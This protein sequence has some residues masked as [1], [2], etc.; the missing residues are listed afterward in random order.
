MIF[1]YHNT[2]IHYQKQGRGSAIVLLHG[3]LES[4]TMWNEVAPRMSKKNTV[5]TIDFPGFGQSDPL[6]ETFSMELLASITSEILNL[7]KIQSALLIGHS[8]GGYVGLAFAALF[9]EKIK[10]LILLNSSPRKDSEERKGNRN[11]ALAIIDKNKDAFVNMAI[12]NLFTNEERLHH[13][14][15]I[16]ALK[17]E[18][19][20]I[21]GAAIKA[22]IIG[23]RDRTDTT[24]ILKSFDG[25]KYI[26]SGRLDPIIPHNDIVAISK[27][28]QTS[29]HTIESGHMSW[30]TNWN[31]IVR[32]V[33]L[34]K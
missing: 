6:A 28:T 27:E 26:I 9:P 14:K 12:S 11:R 10:K 25:E 24:A 29:L 4:S 7:E 23:M 17:R 16:Q 33:S 21:S 5:I 3:F 32:I 19:L 30:L 15:A 31:D 20:Q 8:M 18:A 13:T 34:L 22:A 1:H 2:P